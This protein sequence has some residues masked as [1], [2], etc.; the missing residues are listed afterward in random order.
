MS[1]VILI[2]VWTKCHRDPPDDPMSLTWSSARHPELREMKSKR[3]SLVHLM[4]RLERPNKW[5]PRGSCIVAANEQECGWPVS[6]YWW[7]RPFGT[8]GWVMAAP[9]QPGPSWNGPLKFQRGLL[10]PSLLFC[11]GH[12]T[13][14]HGEANCS[15]NVPTLSLEEMSCAFLRGL[16]IIALL[17]RDAS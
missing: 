17:F 12:R 16:L 14:Q 11:A 10:N 8:R 9:P 7:V 1:P 13:A 4:I 6:H 3:C 2:D 5:T 15:P